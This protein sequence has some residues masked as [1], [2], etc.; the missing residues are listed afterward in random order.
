[1]PESVID[2]W[3]N[4][5]RALTEAWESNDTTQVLVEMLGDDELAVVVWAC[6]G[7][8]SVAW[9]SSNVPALDG[10]RPIDLLSSEPGKDRLRW[11]LLSGPWW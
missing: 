6:L 11:V 7:S 2:N 3:K 10:A 8:Q 5:A 4:L 9:L 1:M